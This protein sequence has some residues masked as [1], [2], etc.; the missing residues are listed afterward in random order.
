MHPVTVLLNEAAAWA[1][2]HPAAFNKS[3]K[4]CRA[5]RRKLL[6]ALLYTHVPTAR[7][8]GDPI[9]LKLQ[10]NRRRLFRFYRPTFR[11]F[12]PFM[13]NHRVIAPF[14]SRSWSFGMLRDHIMWKMETEK[15]LCDR[16]WRWR[17]ESRVRLAFTARDFFTVGISRPE[18]CG[19]GRRAFICW[20]GSTGFTFTLRHSWVTLSFDPSHFPLAIW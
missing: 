16:R 20:C 10:S 8:T 19:G 12:F 15:L 2:R 13:N 1:S 17:R 11:F 6:I 5:M 18:E 7:H 3:T 4:T 14:L 9:S